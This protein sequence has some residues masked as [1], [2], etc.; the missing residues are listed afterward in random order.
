[1]ILAR[2]AGQNREERHRKEIQTLGGPDGL[3]ARLP[4]I[5][6]RGAI[7]GLPATGT[8][9]RGNGPIGACFC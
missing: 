3:V 9:A 8:P 7:C 1:M 2:T 4:G 5:D 6:T